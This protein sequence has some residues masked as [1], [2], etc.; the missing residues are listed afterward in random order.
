V[1]GQDS[2]GTTKR[3]SIMTNRSSSII[4]RISTMCDED[5]EQ[6]SFAMSDRTKKYKKKV[7]VNDYSSS[8]QEDEDDEEEVSTMSISLKELEVPDKIVR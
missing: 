7:I 2:V 8:E 3:K 4:L 6:G 5:S 1:K